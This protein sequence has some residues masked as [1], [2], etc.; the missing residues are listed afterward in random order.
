MD[1]GFHPR[2]RP[3]GMFEKTTWIKL[4]RNVLVGHGVLDDLG[5]GR[6]ASCTSR[7]GR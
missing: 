4:P 5:G 6:S 7:G 3:P 2:A 1:N